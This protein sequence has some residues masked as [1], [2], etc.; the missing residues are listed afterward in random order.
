M[1]AVAAGACRAVRAY[2][3]LGSNLG[4]PVARLRSAFAAL[5]AVPA[6]RLAARSGLYRNPALGG[7]PQP[8]YV[9]AVAALETTLSAPALL[10]ELQ[11]IE[12]CH[13]RDR[14]G[15]RRWGPRTLDLDLLLYGE[16]R[17]ALGER[18][19]VPHPRLAERAF[20]LHPLLELA[21]ALEVPGLGPLAALAA[22]VPGVALVP[23]EEP[24]GG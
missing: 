5:A 2:V 12:A 18:L 7:P 16:E 3:G 6:T 11:R 20:V 15:E 14:S 10:A 19:I 21:P 13:G 22:A 8:D 17:I 24:P 1:S 9:N 23:I 4:G